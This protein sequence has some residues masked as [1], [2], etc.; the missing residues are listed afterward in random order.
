M[1]LLGL[2][3]GAL[4]AW[5]VLRSRLDSAGRDRESATSAQTELTQ[6]RTAAADARTQ[7]ADSRSETATIR[8]ELARAEA[9]L[10]E[11]R[12]EV[13]EART[14]TARAQSETA[15]TSS[16]LAAA[17]A[18]RDA[19]REHAKKLAEDR[20]AL[21]NQFKVLSTETLERQGRTADATAADRLNQTK[22]LIDPLTELMVRFSDRLAQVE[23]ERATMATDLRNQVQAVQNTGE[24]LRHQTNALS[25]AL[26][27]PQVRGTWG[28]LQL[29][30]VAEY[31]GMVDRCD[32][33]EQDSTQTSADR[34][35]RPDMRVNLSDGKF[36]YVDSKVP[37]SAFLDAFETEDERVRAEKL[38]LFG[39]NVRTHID[40][41][42][43]KQ[44][45][46]ADSATPEFVVM[47][48]PNEQFLFTA[49]EQCPD[50]HE[51][52]ASRDVVIATPNTLI[53]ML[54]AVAYGWKQALLAE[55]AAEV[56]TL[57]RELHDR[58]ATMG[59]HLDK[60]G[61]GLKSAVMAYNQALSSMESRVLVSARRFR[62]LKVTD[63]DL[64]ALTPV[65]EPVRELTA[66]ELIE[67]A[68]RAEPMIGREPRGSRLPEAEELTRREP[69]LLG[70]AEG[71]PK[72]G[73][74]GR[75][76]EAG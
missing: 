30:R 56:F 46:K 24:Q 41:L 7:V 31:A 63:N 57:G 39:R 48:L 61:R 26:R 4:G 34:A 2:V 71:S 72:R 9:T 51:Y 20:E 60:A 28:E 19:A 73:S 47:F 10:A 27:K 54:R 43:K 50:L 52:A 22:Q 69:D 35:I 42:S 36:I 58:I 38:G 53:A 40:Q 1:L 66:S 11:R 65:D 32:F 17:R 49:L 33:V 64:A 74:A 13:A 76:S 29:R 37:L 12:S 45:W 44:Y 62:D 25:T 21:V 16:Q 75:D 67:D 14:L 5:L 55:S 59:G 8:A 6:A 70:W 18:E 68:V 3:L 15:E 23:K